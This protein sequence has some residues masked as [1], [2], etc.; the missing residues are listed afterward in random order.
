MK[1]KKLILLV[2]LELLIPVQNFSMIDEFWKKCQQV[3]ERVNGFADRLSLGLDQ[4]DRDFQESARF[5]SDSS[6]ESRH[7]IVPI[8]PEHQESAPTE[9]DDVMAFAIFLFAGWWVSEEV[10]ARNE[11]HFPLPRNFSS[12][13]EDRMLKES[14]QIISPV[15]KLSQNPMSNSSVE[16]STPK[17]IFA[18]NSETE[19]AEILSSGAFQ[20]IGS[21][22][23]V[24]SR[25]NSLN[26]GWVRLPEVNDQK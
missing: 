7:A 12:L 10:E 13:E 23:N 18:N 2:V 25:T 14:Q 8:A 17:T 4:L 24:S 5:E 9:I 3:G 11:V 15:K 19:V 22:T 16:P 6:A 1:N 20:R 21:D 26:D